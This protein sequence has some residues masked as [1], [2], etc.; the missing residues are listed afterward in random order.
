MFC[1][2]WLIFA[3]LVFV[4]VVMLKQQAVERAFVHLSILCV[5]V[6]LLMVLIVYG[7]RR[8]GKNKTD[9]MQSTM[10]SFET[11]SM[12]NPCRFGVRRVLSNWIG[13]VSVA[14]T[15]MQMQAFA[16]PP[17]LYPQELGLERL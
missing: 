15:V 2:T 13:L 10:H 9:T 5:A 4:L 7:H 3:P 14:L 12:L 8:Y 1:F 11:L 17:E 6:L 16:A